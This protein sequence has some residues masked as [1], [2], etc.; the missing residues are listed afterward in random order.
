MPLIKDGQF[1]KGWEYD[2]RKFNLKE[3]NKKL[4]NF[5]LAN[6]YAVT[7][8]QGTYEETD[9]KGNKKVVK[10]MSFIVIDINDTGKLKKVLTTAGKRFR[11]EAVTFS[12]KGG[13]YYLI[14]CFTGEEYKLGSPMFGKDGKIISKVRGETF[15]LYWI[16]R[17]R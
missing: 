4:K 9:P 6:G 5:L 12:E 11:Q 10:E 7:Q 13:D 15:Y 17:N 16:W 3:N 14:I 2:Y 1:R 8:I